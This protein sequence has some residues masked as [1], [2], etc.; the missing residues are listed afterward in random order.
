MDASINFGGLRTMLR[1]STKKLLLNR[2]WI[3]VV[4]VA[5][6]VGLV[7]G[8]AATQDVDRLR[9]G[10]DL[11]NSLVLSFLLPVMAMIY[12]AS[13][14]RN[15][16]DDRSIAQ[17]ITSPVDR[18]VSYLGYYLSLVAVLAVMLL[19]VNAVGWGSF[20]LQTGVDRAALGL[21]AS[22][23]AVLVLGAVVYS[24]LFLLLGLV[25]KQPM[26]LGLFYAFVW[27][28]FIGTLPGNIGM[29][30][31]NRQLAVIAGSLNANIPQV[32]GS[33]AASAAALV[34]VAIVLLVLG[35]VAFREKEVP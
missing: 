11:L 30:T 17:V 33:E 6:L 10:S 35:A 15:E 34:I 21:L 31:I 8:Y 14:I 4:L 16:I 13:M 5:V 9:T 26:Y 25:L 19:I 32:P 28:G 27:E 24:T 1:Y 12:G 2:R 20:F 22:Y 29:L 3:I 18:R 23:S 7:M